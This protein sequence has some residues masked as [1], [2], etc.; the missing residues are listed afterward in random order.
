MRC[1]TAALGAAVARSREATVL[2]RHRTNG[3]A[4]GRRDRRPRH[5]DDTTQPPA[6][7]PD[8]AP[9]SGAL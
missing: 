6:W 4:P 2:V 7:R 5:G 3:S 1:A 8:R 9:G